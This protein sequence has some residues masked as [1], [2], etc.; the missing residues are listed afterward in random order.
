MLSKGFHVKF[1]I[2]KVID[3]I[4]TRLGRF[5]VTLSLTG[6]SQKTIATKAQIASVAVSTK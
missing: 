2:R 4:L 3:T 5:N 6:E 1:S